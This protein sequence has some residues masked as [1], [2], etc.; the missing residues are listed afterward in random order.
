MSEELEKKI[1]TLEFNNKKFDTNIKKSQRSLES[2]KKSLNLEEGVKN[3]EE[4]EKASGEALTPFE[5]SITVVEK[6]L[7]ALEMVAFS[8]INRITN[9]VIDMGEKFVASMSIDQITS[10]WAKYESQITSMQTLV[11]ALNE[12]VEGAAALGFN[13]ANDEDRVA[14]INTYQ[15][16]LSKFY[17]ETSADAMT[18]MKVISNY[19]SQQIPLAEA[20]KAVYGIYAL[21]ASAGQPLSSVAEAANVFTK[22]LGRQ[23]MSGDYFSLSTRM[24]DTSEF[25][26]LVLDTAA[27]MGELEKVGDKYYM[28]QT[29]SNATGIVGGLNAGILALG[30]FKSGVSD[31]EVTLSTFKDTL[32]K[33]WLSGKTMSAALAKMGD[34]WTV[35]EPII[36]FTQSKEAK[37]EAG[38]VGNETIATQ[39][40]KWIRNWSKVQ[41]LR[42]DMSPEERAKVLEEQTAAEDEF[43][44]TIMAEGYSQEK[45]TEWFKQITNEQLEVSR[46]AFLALQEAKSFSEAVDATKV[47]VAT[48]FSNIFQ[49]LSGDYLQ[50]RD[51]FTDFSEW[52]YEYFVEPMDMLSEAFEEWSK[53]GGFD[54]LYKG[55]DEVVEYEDEFG[56]LVET[57]EHFD[58][59]FGVLAQAVDSVIGPISKVFVEVFNINKETIT[60][61]IQ[62]VADKLYSFAEALVLTEDEQNALASTVR[63]IL[64]VF[65]AFG[66]AVSFVWR[67]TEPLRTALSMIWQVVV[68]LVTSISNGITALLE[69]EDAAEEA[70]GLFSVIESAATVIVGLIYS[71]I[72]AAT[73]L[74]NL[75]E[76]SGILGSIKD[77]VINA[78]SLIGGGIQW[79]G[80]E[81]SGLFDKISGYFKGGEA[82]SF[83][84][85]ISSFFSKAS[86]TIKKKLA[87]KD[88]TL[89]EALIGSPEDASNQLDAVS[90]EVAKGKKSGKVDMLDLAGKEGKPYSNKKTMA[91]VAKSIGGGIVGFLAGVVAAIAKAIRSSKD[92][93]KGIVADLFDIAKNGIGEAFKAIKAVII[94]ALDFIASIGP[95]LNAAVAGIAG[96]LVQIS[97]AI[98]ALNISRIPKAIS[99][100]IAGNA[101][102]NQMLGIG[103][104][105]ASVA[106]VIASIIGAVWALVEMFDKYDTN[107]IITS[108]AIVG[109]SLAAILGMVGL[110]IGLL[111]KFANIQMPTTFSLDNINIFK[112]GSGL[113]SGSGSYVQND[114]GL[115]SV[116]VII[117]CV[118]ALLWSVVGAIALLGN[119]PLEK[120]WRGFGVLML[121]MSIL[122]GLITGMVILIGKFGDLQDPWIQGG[123]GKGGITAERHGDSMIGRVSGVIWGAVAMMFA[124]VGALKILESID[125]AKDPG[126]IWRLFGVLVLSVTAVLGMITIL[127]GVV[128]AINKSRTKVDTIAH[129]F[130]TNEYVKQSTGMNGDGPLAQINKVIIALSLFMI[131]FAATAKIL[132]KIPENAQ[133]FVKKMMGIMFGIIAFMIVAVGA[134]AMFAKNNV[135][136]TEY[137]KVLTK[138]GSLMKSMAWSLVIIAIGIAALIGAAM[139]AYNAIM[140][141]S[142]GTSVLNGGKL[143]MLITTFLVAGGIMVGLFFMAKSFLKEAGNGSSKDLAKAAGMFVIMSLFITAIAGFM[144]VLVLIS[145]LLHKKKALGDFVVVLVGIIAMIGAFVSMVKVLEKVSSS[146]MIKVTGFFALFGAVVVALAAALSLLVDEDW[147][148]LLAVTVPLAAIIGG[149]IVMMK[150]LES[151]KATQ[152]LAAAGTFVLFAAAVTLIAQALVALSKIDSKVFNNTLEKLTTL[153]IVLGAAAVILTYVGS[154]YDGLGALFMLAGGA[155]M[156]LFASAVYV[157]AEAISTIAKSLINA[158]KGINAL[159]GV[160]FDGLKEF[161]KVIMGI[162]LRASGVITLL[163][164]IG[165]FF[166]A[167]FAVIILSIAGAIA[168]VTNSITNLIEAL[169]KLFSI[170][171]TSKTE[172]FVDRIAALCDLLVT[173]FEIVGQRLISMAQTIGA[174]VT[175]GLVLGFISALEALTKDQRLYTLGVLLVEALDQLVSGILDKLELKFLTWI[176]DLYGEAGWGAPE[177]VKT[178]ITKLQFKM[179]MEKAATGVASGAAS[180]EVVPSSTVTA[181]EVTTPIQ[182]KTAG[183]VGGLGNTAAGIIS[184]GAS[185]T[186]I[187]IDNVINIAPG[188]GMDTEELVEVVV[189]RFGQMISEKIRGLVPI[190]ANQ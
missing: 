72:D 69:G 75:L 138:V 95:K 186:N 77:F 109:I 37:E 20:E 38:E 81:A 189:D 32:S 85:K 188:D 65:K 21:V 93:I 172:Q 181:P 166:G 24:L 13:F 47:G 9:K 110:F 59:L 99:T 78:A 153:M 40:S 133:E 71:I 154:I 128:T 35:L 102:A 170:V 83:T 43:I 147:D 48:R 44:A 163:G 137:A 183:Y 82:D 49:S 53:G 70:A 45:A 158:V 58:S 42:E 27:E 184:P 36:S 67:A 145:G 169:I 151:V 180:G 50:A 134:I 120:V 8:V 89:A 28:S 132:S 80:N 148:S 122:L 135:D 149:F 86:E 123:I 76:E 100:A 125:D 90:K 5:K 12:E 126:K 101:R 68:E 3:F 103:A 174:G 91:D 115:Y 139:L 64:S 173:I 15:D 84:S 171:D 160:N 143:A 51:I 23:F 118:I 61:T 2:F 113:F 94:D 105:I 177:W 52:L 107:T 1:V 119:I 87:G 129:G 150:V 46:N 18:A 127:Y 98:T 56:N 117:G 29:G 30:N 4:L 74:F 190:G 11:H 114:N 182:N 26:Q 16:R 167:G 161:S 92:S 66:K 144:T 60:E 88:Q 141:T 176:S 73:S 187:T 152:L 17:D 104:I 97:I 19:A 136:Y 142:G 156:L 155:T 41:K 116:A 63:M 162:L 124:V 31:T 157:V 108:L 112:R 14:Y 106:L 33:G 131:S 159:N 140:D 34:F 168:I 175:E 79:I 185:E 7:T 179:G 6:K 111:M 25:K 57:V 62:K 121:S 165:T 130:G 96:A 39:W 10:G 178:N 146:D 22:T 55:F 54:F 164:V